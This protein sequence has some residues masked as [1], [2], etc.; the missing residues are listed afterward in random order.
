M[1]QCSNEWSP[2]DPRPAVRLYETWSDLLPPFIRDNFLDQLVL[3]KVSA[4]V[5]NWNSRKDKVSLRAIVFPWL[6]HVGLRMESFV[7]D[8]RRKVKSIIRS[9]S[10]RDGPISDLPSWKEV[11]DASEWD[12]I[13]LKYIVPKLGSLLRDEL[14]INPR[15]QKLE[16]LL[17]VLQ[18]ADILRPTIIGQL[19]EV[20]FFPKWLEVLHI[21]LIQ[22]TVNFGEV[23]EWYKSW[24]D[25]FPLNVQRIPV[26]EQG[27][28]KGL[29][30]MEQ[31]LEL[32]TDAPRKLPKPVFNRGSPTPEQKP[33][34]KAAAK[35]H[36]SRT[37]EITFRSIVE[38]FAASHNL[39]FMPAG[40]V[41]EKSRLPLFR[42]SR[43]ADGKGGILVYLLDDAVWFVDGDDYRAISLE[44][45]VLK[46]TKS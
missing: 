29:Q 43:S 22:P 18:W 10:P 4:A 38:E 32:G 6:P 36:A 1:H 7:E 15:N 35:T 46:A 31:A 20:E 21:W 34:A 41:H 3:P 28:S 37:Q 27:F 44:D 30:M 33:S 11:F 40:K 13:L 14:R 2:A 8:A 12:N 39:L 19:L 5:S 17:T 23:A 9:W 45:M 24:K 42:V 25:T 26:V 16:P